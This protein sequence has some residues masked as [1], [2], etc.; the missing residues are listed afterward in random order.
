[1][2]VIASNRK[3]GTN[4]ILYCIPK[5][6]EQQ[7]FEIKLNPRCIW[8]NLGKPGMAAMTT[9][10]KSI[11]AALK[12]YEK[13]AFEKE[14]PGLE[15]PAKNIIVHVQTRN[16]KENWSDKH[17]QKEITRMSL[18]NEIMKTKRGHYKQVPF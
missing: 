14:F 1:M 7:E 12:A 4:P 9:I 5:D 18:N 2:I 10:Q 17:I 16:Q 15:I 3:I 13:P 11:L 8:E 6:A